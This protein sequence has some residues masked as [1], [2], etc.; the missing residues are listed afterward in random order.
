MK[1][2]KCLPF[3]LLPA[4]VSASV[5]ALAARK[6]APAAAAE[7]LPPGAIDT[8]RVVRDPDYARQLLAD[9]ERNDERLD[10]ADPEQRRA[11]VLLRIL[12]LS[13]LDRYAD[14]LPFTKQL[15]QELPG[16]VIGYA[17]LIP[18]AIGANRPLEALDGIEAALR[19]LSLDRQRADL[20]EILADDA[21]R[22]LWQQLGTPRDDAGRYRLAEALI[23]LQWP[24]P[25]DIE[26]IDRNRQTAIEGR[27]ARNDTASARALAA[28]IATPRPLIEL[29][30]QRRFD[31]VFGDG[32]DPSAR[33]ASGFAAYDKATA[34]WLAAQPQEWRALVARTQYLR[35][36]GRNDAAL[37]LIL[38]R[39]ADMDAVEKGGEDAAWLVNEAGY[40]LLAAGRTD[41][42]LA[43]MQRLIALD[44]EKHS[45]LVSMSINYAEMLNNAGRFREALAHAEAL[46]AKPKLASPYGLMWIWQSAACANLLAGDAAAAAPWLARLKEK[47]ADN[48][49]AYM[50]ALLCAN[51]LDG[52]ER[53]LVE[54]LGNAEDAP[55]ALVGLQDYRP[56]P[57]YSQS[58]KILRERLMAVRARPAVQAAVA[59]VGRILTLPLS[60]VYWG[61]V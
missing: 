4:L 7:P 61:E 2:L 46:S 56:E 29:L 12:A 23:E 43:L 40:A 8:E 18:T 10:R 21:V 11:L 47:A 16:D 59:R 51:D 15:V 45:Y 34:D 52:A 19:N 20:R 25:L 17:M 22:A 5:P 60:Q 37:A 31:P 35:R 38:P 53:L 39:V 9:L 3:L 48:R 24:V 32:P 42:A 33:L 28:A 26:S 30:V 13:S 49:P 41:E 44:V 54:R 27:V 36:A 50:R 55:R 58:R 14:A 6:A 57:D 1:M